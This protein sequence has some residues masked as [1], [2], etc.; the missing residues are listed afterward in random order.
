MKSKPTQLW[1][2]CYQWLRDCGVNINKSYCK[3]E[4]S[5]HP[6]YPALTSVI[7]FLESG[8]M[9]Y[10]AVKADNSYINEFNY[11]VLA[12]IQLPGQEYLHIVPDAKYW[13]EQKEITQNW[14]GVVIIPTE[15]T[16]WST[17][18]N[19]AYL[20]SQ[21]RK[22]ILATLLCSISLM[23]FAITIYLTPNFLLNAFG[24]LSLAGISIS[25]LLQANELGFQSQ[26]VKQVCSAFSESGCERVIK[27]SYGRG[28]WGVTP[29]DTSLLYFITQFIIY[30]VS[31]LG[32]SLLLTGLFTFAIA[33]TAVMI[34]SLYIQAV[35]VKS[36]CTL[37]L[38]VV[39][40]LGGQ[41][42]IALLLRE[43]S[44]SFVSLGTFMLAAA[45]LALFFFPVKELL[46]TNVANDIKLVELR[47][48]KSD[49][50]L[51]ISKWQQEQEVD[52]P[53][54]Q[55]DLILGS[56]HAPLCITAACNLYCNPCAKTHL[57]LDNLIERYGDHVCV[58][59]RILVSSRDFTEATRAVLQ[60]VAEDLPQDTLQAV[61]TSWFEKMDLK[62]W[63]Q[64]WQP[65]STLDVQ[66]RL[67]Q[68]QFWMTRN[69][70]VTTP[71][72]FLND[73]KIPGQYALE[74]V[75]RL[76]PQLLELMP[77]ASRDIPVHQ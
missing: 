17:T 22:T 38:V 7:D 14:S 57:A 46:K 47:R 50:T 13:D 71:T 51:F 72:L 25:V 43:E 68:H 55:H 61:M 39:V 45:V 40:I 33:A 27:S 32:S 5:T 42:I 4:V 77:L 31:C 1:E 6:D 64:L 3:E 53:K 24:L 23:V 20:H 19:T 36:W 69:K 30:V 52:D 15:E 34:W 74:D 56:K 59:I 35:K 54:W 44:V 49:G 29:A 2:V 41:S 76:I 18:T 26:I 28:V 75:E 67:E 66:E 48:F 8:C 16:S 65:D 11:P 60:K 58:K 37:C 10:H 21:R 63:T 12:H 73:R 9:A 62:Y 70:I